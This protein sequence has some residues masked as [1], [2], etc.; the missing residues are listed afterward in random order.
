VDN[1]SGLDSKAS[2]GYW[3]NWLRMRRA[4]EWARYTL[5]VYLFIRRIRCS[6]LILVA[7][8]LIDERPRPISFGGCCTPS[9]GKDE[10]NCLPRTFIEYA[11]DLIELS[12][13]KDSVECCMVSGLKDLFYHKYFVGRA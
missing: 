12:I 11:V 6:I 3:L 7:L 13:V 8:W 5:S 9:V 2:V 1:L 10:A 4:W